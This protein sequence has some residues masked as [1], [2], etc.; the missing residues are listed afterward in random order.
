[1]GYAWGMPFVALNTP[2]GDPAAAARWYLVRDAEILTTGPGQLPAG[3]PD[4]LGLAEA[5]DTV[6]VYLGDDDGVAC[7]ARGVGAATPPPEGARWE[8][9]MRLGASVPAPAWLVAG[10]AV[11]LV[12]WQRTTR[13]C[14]RCAS[15]T[16]A[17]AAERAMRC[18]ECGLTSY[19]RLAPAVIVLIRRGRRALLARNA[20]FSGRMFSALAG[21]VEPGETLEE[22]VRR[23]VAEEVGVEV[24]TLRYFGSQPWPFPHSLM[25]GF[26]AEWR[27]GE[28]QVDGAEIAEAGWFEPDGLPDV[29]PPLSIARRLI[30]AWRDEGIPTISARTESR[31]PTPSTERLS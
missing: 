4:E 27:S 12:E 26:M 23:E 5:S 10:R 25:V 17:L 1:M 29:P 15:A 6:P 2:P 14:G 28:I 19:P 24:G 8:P 3:S 20:R 13:F 7:W 31:D 18:P 16:E 9:L 30:D 21:F 11:Q 22:A